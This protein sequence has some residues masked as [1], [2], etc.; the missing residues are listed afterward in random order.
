[1]FEVM[2]ETLFCDLVCGLQQSYSVT[3][4]LANGE[5]TQKNLRN[6]TGV[7]HV[8]EGPYLISMKQ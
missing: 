8:L 6:P 1:M 3:W 7:V 5:V 4:P 2:L